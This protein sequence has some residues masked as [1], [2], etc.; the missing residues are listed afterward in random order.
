MNEARGQDDDTLLSDWAG[1]DESAGA[2]LV[3][4]H[5]ASVFG[6]FRNKVDGPIEDLT[7]ATFLA[8]LD[9]RDR[10]RGDA[11]FRPFL[12]GIARYQL[13]RFFRER[14]RSERSVDFERVCV[15][16]LSQTA[17]ETRAV[18]EVGKVMAY[19]LRRIPIDLQI[20]IE[21]YYW[22]GLSIAEVAAATDVAPG[23][24]KSRLGRARERLRQEILAAPASHELQTNTLH[25]LAQWAREI[26]ELANKPRA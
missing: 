23:T 24:V 20:A 11:G 13:L 21:L 22:E 16:D 1:G 9:A 17:S 2:T 26:D 19:A 18:A 6:F 15:A 8:C 5:Y 4:R 10:Y 7:Q 12:F 14:A 3:R 25:R